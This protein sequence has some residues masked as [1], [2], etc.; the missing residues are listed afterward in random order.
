MKIGNAVVVLS[1]AALAA[2]A[3]FV[4]S[5]TPAVPD[6]SYADA[7]AVPPPPSPAPV[8]AGF[9][10]QRASRDAAPRP[11]TPAKKD[12]EVTSQQRADEFCLEDRT[13]LWDTTTR[14]IEEMVSTL[15]RFKDDEAIKY[16]DLSDDAYEIARTRAEALVGGD[17]RDASAHPLPPRG[18]RCVD[19]W[20]PVGES[21]AERSARR[22]GLLATGEDGTPASATDVA[23]IVEAERLRIQQERRRAAR[24]YRFE[25]TRLR[26]DLLR[27]YADYRDRRRRLS[28]WDDVCELVEL[29]RNW[30]DRWDKWC[31]A[32]ADSP[33]D[34]RE[35]EALVRTIPSRILDDTDLIA[36]IPSAAG[37]ADAAD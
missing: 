21:L 23:A 24:E 20:V 30:Q 34:Q 31:G 11:T 15:R 33:E 5:T 7:A 28:T 12:P 8:L 3:Q 27:E 26:S 17:R 22:R 6:A 19:E 16:V 10:E 2:A 29:E 13:P 9:T 18:P 25:V 1:L 32:E 4:R 14:R 37:D 36:K 35:V